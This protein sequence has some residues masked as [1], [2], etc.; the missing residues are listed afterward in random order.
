MISGPDYIHLICSDLPR[1]LLITYKL[2]VYGQ[3]KNIYLWLYPWIYNTR[4]YIHV[5]VV[6]ERSPKYKIVPFTVYGMR[7][8][9]SFSISH[10]FF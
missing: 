1:L 5:T 2:R 9:K 3:L 8:A 10:S 7:S 6:E 4:I